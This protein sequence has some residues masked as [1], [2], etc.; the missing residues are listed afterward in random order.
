MSAERLPAVELDPVRRLH[1]MAAAIPGAALVEGLLDA[2]FDP[3]W[4]VATDFEK[5]ATEIEPFL[6]SARILS[7][8]GERLEL[9][10]TAPLGMHDRIEV[11]LRPGW[12]WMQSPML[13]AAMAAVPEGERTRFAHL[14]A[15]RFPGARLLGPVLAMKMRVARELHK[16]E[17]LARARPPA[18]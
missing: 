10:Y 17:R 4:S 5:G 15:F 6:S 9:V 2:P 16:I 18:G 7:H 1:A 11:V 13:V 3:V 14:E 8:E 12:C